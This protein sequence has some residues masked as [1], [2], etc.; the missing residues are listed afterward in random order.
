MTGALDAIQR[1]HL[2]RLVGRARS[3][4]E[5]DLAGQAAG[6]FGIDPDGTIAG[7]DDLR[8]DPTELAARRELVDVVAHLRSEGDA[9]PAAVARL[10]REAVF[11]HLNRLVA[12]RIAEALGLL[13]PSLADGRRSRGF[14]DLLE[15]APLFASDDTGGYWTYLQLCG[16]ELASDVPTLFD[17]RNPLLALV[18]SPAALDDLVGLLSDPSAAELWT[19]SDCIGWMYQFFNTGDE[20][21]A[22]REGS[23]A[24]HNSRELAVRNQF[25]TPRYVVDFLVHN[26]LGRRLMDAD[27]ASPLLDELP[28]LVDPPTEQGEP[29]PLDDVSVLDPACGSG[30]FLLAAYDVLER[31][32]HHAGVGPAEAAPAIVQSLWGID[33]D[34]R[35]SQVAAAALIFRARRSCP[36]GEIPRPNIVC[37]RAL[38]PASTGLDELLAPLPAGQRLLV[39]QFTEVLT[40][41][42][43]LGSLLKVEERLTAE[44]RSAVF[45]APAPSGTLADGLADETLRSLEADLLANVSMVADSTISSPA[46]RLLAAEADDAIRYVRA[47]QRRYDTVLMN[48]PFGEPVPET[49]PYLKAAYPWIPRRDYNLFAA[50]VGRGLELCQPDGYVGAITS[51]VGLFLK[52]FEAWRRRVLLGHH[53]I[54]LADLGCGVMEQAL[55]EAAA[56]VVSASPTRIGDHAAF[57]RLLNDTERSAGL[58]G[59]V[60][61][62][63]AGRQDHRVFLVDIADLQAIPGSPVAYWISPAIRRLFTE[64]PAVEGQGAEVRVGLQTGDD[65]RFVRVFWE[66]S[67][68][69]IARSRRETYQGKRWVPFAKG[70]EYSPYW[71]DIHLVVN[72]VNDGKELREFPGSVIRNPQYFF[73]PGLT[74]PRRTASGFGPRILPSGTIFADKGPAILSAAPTQLLGWLHARVTQAMLNSMVAAADTVTSGGAAKSYE[75]G[76]VQKLPWIEALA[77]NEEI[78]ALVE[79]VVNLRQQT[80]IADETTRQFR[81]PKVLRHISNGNSLSQAVELAVQEDICRSL[82]IIEGTAEIEHRIHAI[83]QLDLAAE[84]YLNEEVGP[85]PHSYRSGRLDPDRFVRLFRAPLDALI[86]EVIAEKGGARAV[87]NL[88]YFADRRL[89]VLAHALERPPRQLAELRAQLGVLPPGEPC[90]SARELLSYLLGLALGR[91]DVRFG[92]DWSGAFP[93]L[94]PFDPIP[95]C[96]PG[97]LVG[98]DGSPVRETPPEYPLELPLGRL[99]LDEPG[100][101]WDIEG[102]MIAASHLIFPGADGVVAELLRIVGQ[103][104]IRDYLR[105]SFFKEHLSRYSKS[106]RKSPIYWPLYVSSG[107]WGV[108][109]YAPT[110]SRETLFAVARAAADRLDAAET[111]I[112]RLQ[113]ERNAGGAGRTRREV[114]EAL[115]SEEQL[116]E[117]LRRF[118]QEAERIAGLG[119]EPDLDDGIILCVAPLADLFPAWKDAGDARKEIK[120]GEYPW[121]TVSRWAGQL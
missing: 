71:F 9:P 88:T 103:R 6:R 3:I 25:F 48:P 27:P 93:T 99:L 109:I 64:Y 119:W 30:H 98:D 14:R 2:E 62:A 60:A 29:L 116:A 75:V 72:Y 82:E 91:W 94:S 89:E 45:G 21:R 4:L 95:L 120:A 67:P 7:D 114:T 46:E 34:P 17:P 49:K 65:F 117:E 107:A 76:L 26:S 23:A 83:V 69:R 97:M 54:A 61:A 31:A 53:L 78:A 102:R 92:R 58:I 24:P 105:R 59:A 22:M 38:P 8:L 40:D 84:S 33:I 81:T 5:V 32:W 100:H 121:A 28:L 80:D 73:R 87:A 68:A 12:I 36:E 118:R 112:R 39:R 37:A 50:F 66:V 85:H 110:L 20:R 42:P 70:G 1:T 11:T 16:D 77:D 13:P 41:A 101:R 111:E 47:L 35:C 63:R 15:L 51:R 108:W 96:P 10:L 57:I 55:V 74:W 43:V 56:Y 44:V 79:R 104:S 106:R 19:A 52:T 18:P 86:D 113:R 90:G 115:A